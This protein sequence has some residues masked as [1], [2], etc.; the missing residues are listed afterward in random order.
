MYNINRSALVPYSSQKM[1][2]LVNDVENY[3]NFLPWCGGSEVIEESEETSVAS[4]TIAFKGV[5]KTFTTANRLKYHT[6]IRIAMVDGPFSKL[7]GIWTFKALDEN[8]CKL[9]V[10]L[11]F[12]F[13]N[14][15]VGAVIGPVFKI[16]ADSMIDSFCKRAE[17]IYGKEA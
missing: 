8:A 6:E 14:R 5:H 15:I 3:K 12:D 17:Q 13:S 4:I 2:D 11:D 10:D 7:E 16:I 9:S 1:F